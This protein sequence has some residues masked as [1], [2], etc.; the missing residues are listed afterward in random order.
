MNNVK[1]MCGIVFL[2]I[3]DSCERIEYFPDRPVTFDK[4]RI[5]AHQGGGVFDAGNTFEACK[6]GLENAEGIEVDIQRSSDNVLWLSHSSLTSSCGVLKETCFASVSNNTIIA[7][8]SCLGNKIN[9]TQLETIFAYMS[10]HYPDK[11]ISLDVKAWQP[12]DISNVNV[13]RQMNQMAQVIIDLVSKYHMGGRVMVESEVGDFLFYIKSHSHD[14]ETYLVSLGDLELGISRALEAKFSGV[15]FHY[16]FEEPITEELVDL[17][18]RKG[19]KIQLWTVL[20]QDISD[21][22]AVNP[23]FIQTDYF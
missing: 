20:S 4:T 5:I 13:I 22:K 6:Y 7:I 9:Y 18:H 8:D 10:D 3:L 1:V 23:D 16:K 14:I 2:L 19:L 21:A 17:I 12:C 15:S 11:F